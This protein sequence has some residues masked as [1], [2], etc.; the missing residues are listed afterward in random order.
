MHWLDIPYLGPTCS[1]RTLLQL[2]I[3][4]NKKQRVANLLQHELD[5]S[6]HGLTPMFTSEIHH[7]AA[8]VILS[9]L[10]TGIKKGVFSDEPAALTNALGELQKLS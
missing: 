5:Q 9:M 1:S 8:C 4:E 10:C 6:T 3:G 7:R 2:S